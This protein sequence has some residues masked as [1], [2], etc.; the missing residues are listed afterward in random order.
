MLPKPPFRKAKRMSPKSVDEVEPDVGGLD[1]VTLWRI[2]QFEALGF[3][4]LSASVLV[5]SGADH[6]EA[7]RLL[8]K[9]GTT[10]D[11]VYDQLT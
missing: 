8:A 3:T 1:D 4:P 10:L 11:F 5:A 7:R 2:E 9:T 6:H